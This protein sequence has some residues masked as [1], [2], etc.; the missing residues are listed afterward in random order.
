MIQI[1]TVGDTQEVVKTGL[2]KNLPDKLYIL[3]TENERTK[4]EFDSEIKKAK[5]EGNE[6][7]EH[8]LKT[9]QYETNVKLLKKEIEKD[10]KIDV[11]LKLVHKFESNIVINTILSIISKE[12]KIQIKNSSGS[13]LDIVH[14]SENFAINITGG[15]KAMVAGAACA[16]YLSQA[17]MYYVL[18]PSEAR[19]NDLVRELPVPTKTEN[20]SRGG[21]QKTT[22]IILSA[23]RKFE[24]P[25]SPTTLRDDLINSGVKF[26]FVKRDKKTN[27]EITEL[28]SFSPQLIAFHTGKLRDANL[29]EEIEVTRKTKSGKKDRRVKLLALTTSGQYYADYPDILGSIL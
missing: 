28:R 22:S 7:R 4:K 29:V 11:E 13:Y 12:K 23:I 19:G 8:Y 17:R 3:H 25:V 15:T 1:A 5:Q 27:T 9:K 2:G 18:H 16:A 24:E 6:Q 20:T 21:A 14:N 26:P 10:F